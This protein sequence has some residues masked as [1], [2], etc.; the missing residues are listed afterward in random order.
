MKIIVVKIL[1]HKFFFKNCCLRPKKKLCTKCTKQ[2]HGDSNKITNC[3]LNVLCMQF[4]TKTNVIKCLTF[5]LLFMHFVTQN[6]ICLMAS[7]FFILNSVMTQ[8]VC[9]TF[10]KQNCLF[11]EHNTMKKKKKLN[12]MFSTREI[13]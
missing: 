8:S 7:R 11:S 4:P 5:Y 12:E 13:L 9:F 6:I 1:S 3:H 10:M 2:A